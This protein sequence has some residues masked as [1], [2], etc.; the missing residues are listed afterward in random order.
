MGRKKL[1][2]I[3]ALAASLAGPTSVAV[4]QVSSLEYE[5]L[6][7]IYRACDGDNW[8][9]PW[10][11][12]ANNVGDLS[13]WPGV[14]Q[15]SGHV[16]NLVF[17]YQGLD[18]QLPEQ[19][20]NLAYLNELTI[21]ERGLEGIVPLSSWAGLRKC[22]VDMSFSG[23]TSLGELRQ[24]ES[25]EL[26]NS[27][28][29]EAWLSGSY[30][31]DDLPSLN[32]LSLLN[33]SP[34]L[35]DLTAV[36]RLSS[37][38]Y[39]NNDAAIDIGELLAKLNPES[40]ERLGL[41][42]KTITA[43]PSLAAATQ[44]AVLELRM[45]QGA[46]SSQELLEA[47]NWDKLE[48]L[49]L[50]ADELAHGIPDLFINAVPMRELDIDASVSG[51]LPELSNDD[52]RIGSIRILGGSF[53]APIPGSWQGMDSLRVLSLPGAALTGNFPAFLADL[54]RLQV[55][56]LQANGISGSIPASWSCDG[57]KLFDL[58]NNS[59]E[60][61]LARLPPASSMDDYRF[62]ILDL[63]SNMLSGSLPEG[64]QVDFYE[65]D[66]AE[67]DFSG[68][69]SHWTLEPGRNLIGFDI[70]GN[71]FHGSLDWEFQEMSPY[72][73]YFALAGNRV[74]SIPDFSASASLE[75]L[76]VADNALRFGSLLPNAEFFLTEAYFWPQKPFAVADTAPVA[77][78]GEPFALTA[79][80]DAPGTRFRWF[81][82]G[83]PL[84]PESESPALEIA[85]F[86]PAHAGLYVCQATHPDMPG[87]ALSSQGIRPQPWTTDASG[88]SAPAVAVWPNPASDRLEVES[89]GA[90]QVR[91]LD[92]AGRALASASG[93]DRLA[94]EVS[95]LPSGVYLLELR[96]ASGAAYERVAV[97]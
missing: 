48:R 18:G 10:D 55:L 56:D 12:T 37:F 27:G 85:E 73:G 94:L 40:L 67:N 33:F 69:L 76:S 23:E 65:F 60:G 15:A 19:A 90:F 84:G 92:L 64:Y 82:D 49:G 63:A 41:R 89:P 53:N 51:T 20:Q 21:L 2:L 36:P 42:A 83:E 86:G 59:L 97:R 26:Y 58:S 7:A 30:A 62:S 11:T 29:S 38:V 61:E 25:V 4:A 75:L 14:W 43:M 17:F 45:E 46:I 70:S 71:D 77:Y 72:L 24:L 68:D 93:R 50:E 88:L 79:G 34:D 13:S 35:A 5:A 16:V 9:Q 80:D 3:T 87:L 78:L 22:M 95:T 1:L 32:E 39:E 96:T 47:L 8:A 74:G 91:L 6:K 81:K 54:E 57:F 44:L 31:Y 66:L 28:T 52:S